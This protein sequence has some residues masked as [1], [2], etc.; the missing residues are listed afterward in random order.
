MYHISSEIS[1]CDQHRY[2]SLR[3][4]Y[5]EHYCV[6]LQPKTF[7]FSS[8]QGRRIVRI[9]FLK[10]TQHTCLHTEKSFPV[11]WLA[12]FVVGARGE[13]V[14]VTSFRN[15]N[16]IFLQSVFELALG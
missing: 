8:S 13:G 15:F 16:N 7:P 1:Q 5:F 10:K 9:F 12:S 3:M 14:S 11:I 2:T 4:Y 6:A